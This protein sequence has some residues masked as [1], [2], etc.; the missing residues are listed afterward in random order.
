MIYKNVKEKLP[1]RPQSTPGRRNWGV[2]LRYT[3]PGSNEGACGGGRAHRGWQWRRRSRCL[4]GNCG[5][6]RVITRGFFIGQCCVGKVFGIEF[7]WWFS[8]GGQFDWPEVG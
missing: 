3:S 4:S 5:E 6:Y 8:A 1:V 2:A 7:A